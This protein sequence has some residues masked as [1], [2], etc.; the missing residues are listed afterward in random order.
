MRGEVILVCALLALAIAGLLYKTVKLRAEIRRRAYI[1]DYAWPPGLIDRFRARRPTLSAAEV[2]RVENGLRQYFRAYLAGGMAYVAMPSQVVDDLW[3]EFILYTR[4]YEK[5]CEDA[6]GRFFHHT[7]ALALDPK[8]RESNAGL[9][10]V[11][12]ACCDEEGINPRKPDRLPLLFALDGETKIPNGFRY[13]TDCKA[14]RDPGAAG[15]TYCGGD[16][17]DSSVDGSTAGFGGSDGDGHGGSDG[18]GDGGG[19]GGSSC[20]GGCGGGGD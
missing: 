10:R 16:F 2:F 14:L 1:D 20:G 19:D 6:F 9:R 8:Q 11:W 17:G 7:P 12:R 5:F 13:A 15:G 3:H 4:A 18:G